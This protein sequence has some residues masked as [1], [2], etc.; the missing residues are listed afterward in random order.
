[1]RVPGR[2]SLTD[3]ELLFQSHTYRFAARHQGMRSP[4]RARVPFGFAVC[5]LI[6]DTPG[7]AYNIND[8]LHQFDDLVLPSAMVNQQSYLCSM[9]YFISSQPYLRCK[10]LT[11]I[12]I[13]DQSRITFR[14][15]GIGRPLAC[16][17]WS[18]MSAKDANRAYLP[19][20]KACS[21]S[22]VY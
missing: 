17:A 1:M 7:E 11:S 14:K 4:S 13:G 5:Q 10:Q 3:H 6:H 9:D 2:E 18:G 22:Y 16:C 20:H 21:R 12:G 19:K 8:P 15:F